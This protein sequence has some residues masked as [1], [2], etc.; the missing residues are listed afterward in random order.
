MGT[1]KAR[2]ARPRGGLRPT[3]GFDRPTTGLWSARAPADGTR[4]YPGAVPRPWSCALAAAALLCAGLAAGCTAAPSPEPTAA[5]SPSPSPSAD[6]TLLPVDTDEDSAVGSLAPGFPSAL[7]PVPP[8]AEVL[9]SSAEPLP[10]GR[11][12]I[13]LN[14]R[15]GQDAAGLLDAVRAPLVAAGF[16]ESAPSS[17]EAGLAAR[18]TFSRSDGAELLVVGVLDRDGLRTMTLGG[19]LAAP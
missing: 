13:S 12:A 11:L 10:D 4:G 1:T 17:P 16:A 18:T 14:V 2:V 6:E 8:G 3:C 19:T 5:A 7:V 9:V 15:T